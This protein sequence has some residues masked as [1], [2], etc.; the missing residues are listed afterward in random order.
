MHNELFPRNF[1]EPDYGISAIMRFLP[2]SKGRCSFLYP[3]NIVKKGV[4]VSN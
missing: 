3:V 1:G 4:P 2:G